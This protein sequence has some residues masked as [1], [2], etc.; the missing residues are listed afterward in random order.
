MA[1]LTI[2]ELPFHERPALELLHFDEDRDEVDHDY[3]GYGWARVDHVWL[4]GDDVVRPVDDV[5]VLGL[6][7][8]DDGQAFAEDIEVEFELAPGRSV[9]VMATQ[10]LEAW[11]PK[12]PRDRKAIVLAICNPHRAVL[13]SPTSTIPILYPLGDVTS[14]LE[15]PTED[16]DARIHLEAE[17][18]CTLQA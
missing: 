4:R 7:S 1:S 18:W 12:L 15:L 2:A 11:L 17:T 8:P 14:W 13:R 5:L 10:F 3:A 6:H 16:H 9:I